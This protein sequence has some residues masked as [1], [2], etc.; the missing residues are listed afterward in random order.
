MNDRCS[1]IYDGNKMHIC[2]E[3]F[4]TVEMIEHF[5][6]EKKPPEKDLSEWFSENDFAVIDNLERR[7]LDRLNGWCVDYE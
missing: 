7:T 2:I 3:P 1:L 6:G 5:V 4:P